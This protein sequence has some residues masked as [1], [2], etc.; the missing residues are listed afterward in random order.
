MELITNAIYFIAGL[1]FGFITG[2][3]SG[4]RWVLAQIKKIN[5]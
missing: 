4:I 2:W 1:I 5:N 3:K